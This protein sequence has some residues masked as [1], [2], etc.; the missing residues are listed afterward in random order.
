MIATRGLSDLNEADQ[1]RLINDLGS[2]QRQMQDA[3]DVLRAQAAP[4]PGGD[5]ARGVAHG[6]YKA[7]EMLGCWVLQQVPGA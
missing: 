4:G 1:K 5:H 6:Y 2:L 7:A 3:G